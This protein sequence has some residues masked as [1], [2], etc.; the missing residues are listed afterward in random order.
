M[1]RLL[2]RPSHA[3]VVAYLALFV[4]L[5]GSAMAAFVVSSNSQI[6]PNT[7]YGANKPTSANDNIVDGSITGR[8][9]KTGSIFGSR[10]ADGSV[11]GADVDES[12]LAQVPSAHH[13]EDADTLDGTDA[14]HFA[15]LGGVV[16]ADGSVSQG[17]GFTVAR[18]GPGEY[19]VSFPNGTLA[20]GVCPPIVVATAFSLVYHAAISGRGCSGLGAGS[21]TVQMLDSAGTANDAPFL[22]IAM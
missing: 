4:A 5:G 3:T 10:I 17:T 18:L 8:D 20:P 19:Q 16:N 22:F 9:V 2:R 7:I 21:F 12:S 1:R 13:A 11:L 6:G 15:R 14:K